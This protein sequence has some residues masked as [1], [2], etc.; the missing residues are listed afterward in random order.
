MSHA[1]RPISNITTINSYFF[2]FY[3]LNISKSQDNDLLLLGVQVQQTA[4]WPVVQILGGQSSVYPSLLSHTEPAERWQRTRWR[5]LVPQS[6]R[7]AA[8]GKQRQLD[9]CSSN[10]NQPVKDELI[11]KFVYRV[12]TEAV[13]RRVAIHNSAS[14]YRTQHLSQNVANKSE[15]TDLAA[16]QQAQGHGRVQVSPADVP[17]A[18][19]QRGDRQ[20]KGQR[21]FHLLGDV[22]RRVSDDGGQRQDYEQ[23][24]AH[25][26]RQNCPPEWPLS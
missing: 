8:K 17:Q 13:T 5:C 14:C 2:H 15:E 3:I 18:L 24:H 4:R 9:A 23:Q 16:D 22:R 1:N 6:R 12:D 10:K 11:K 7:W 19:S 21:H 25:K 26:L 20:G